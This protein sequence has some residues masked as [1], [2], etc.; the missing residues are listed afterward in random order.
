M[1]LCPGTACACLCRGGVTS[2]DNGCHRDKHR[3]CM[4]GSGARR[5]IPGVG[6]VIVPI[7]S[8]LSI[9]VFPLQHPWGLKR[10][11]CI[12]SPFSNSSFIYSFYSSTNSIAFSWRVTPPYAFDLCSPINHIYWCNSSLLRQE[13]QYCVPPVSFAFIPLVSAAFSL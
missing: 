8:L 12:P 7:C 6:V 11:T 4:G 1:G 5:D 13:E 9:I 2:K 3:K 10:P